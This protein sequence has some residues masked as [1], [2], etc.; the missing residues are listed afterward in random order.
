MADSSPQT[1]KYIIERVEKDIFENER[2]MEELK[3]FFK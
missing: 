1:A 2:K 3:K